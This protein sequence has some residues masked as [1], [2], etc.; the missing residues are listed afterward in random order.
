MN[1]PHRPRGDGGFTLMD[2]VAGMTVMSVFMVIFTSSLVMM[3]RSSNRSQA[4]AHTSQQ[5]N[6][7]F[8]WLDGKIRYADYVS[9]PGQDPNDGGAWY[10]EF[11][12]TDPNTQEP[13]CHQL[14]VDQAGE[15][16][17]QRS[18]TAGGPASSWQLLATGVTNGGAGPTSDN[19]PFVLLAA[20]QAAPSTPT[21]AALPALPSEQ[22][23]VNLTISEGQGPDTTSSQSSVTLAAFNTSSSTKTSGIC[24]GMRP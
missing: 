20:G 2:L 18:W 12:S 15:Q 11:E 6:S 23:T 4:V 17:Q 1:R 9:T 8:I 7:A 3:F 21:A 10:V 5:V 13:V 14:R 22:L 24:T 19:R 16:L